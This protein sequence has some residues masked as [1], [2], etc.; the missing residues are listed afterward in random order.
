MNNELIQKITDL[1]MPIIDELSYELYHV[2]FVKENGEFYLR[3]RA[4]V[5]KT[6]IE[7]LNSHGCLDG[8]SETNQQSFF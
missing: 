6:V 8:L 4:G 5:S 1:V 2:E 3:I 7:G